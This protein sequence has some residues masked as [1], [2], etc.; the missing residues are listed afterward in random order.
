MSISFLP[1]FIFADQMPDLE[2]VTTGFTDI[3]FD[4]YLVI[5]K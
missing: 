5:D 1:P 3:W 4:G 2:I